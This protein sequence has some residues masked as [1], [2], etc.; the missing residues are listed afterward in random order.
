MKFVEKIRKTEQ[1][2]D[3][4]VYEGQPYEG[5]DVMNYIIANDMLSE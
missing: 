2:P 5:V 3:I 1:Y 4:K